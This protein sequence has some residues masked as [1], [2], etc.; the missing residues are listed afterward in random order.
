MLNWYHPLRIDPTPCLMT[1]ST[2]SGLPPPFAQ[3]LT[4]GVRE[5]G[6][7]R[8]DF[9]QPVDS[10]P[11]T[12]TP[13]VGQ[14]FDQSVNSSPPRSHTNICHSC[15]KQ[16]D[17]PSHA[18]TLRLALLQPS[19]Y[20]VARGGVAW[21][22]VRGWTICMTKENKCFQSQPKMVGQTWS[23]TRPKRLHHAPKFH[24]RRCAFYI[25]KLHPHGS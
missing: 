8:S 13:H 3:H 21:W 15:N 22:Y 17:S 2:F 10:L 12:L 25:S 9:D 20:L 16:V 6:Y 1:A 23:H 5:D 19:R 18:H 7:D 24:C 14:C 4:F 11:S